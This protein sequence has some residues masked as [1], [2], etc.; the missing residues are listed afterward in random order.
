[1]R[2]RTHAAF[3][4]LVRAYSGD[5][6]RFAYWISRDTGIAEDIVQETFSR[7]WKAWHQLKD[8]NAAKAW[9]LTIAR[10]EFYRLCQR[11]RVAADEDI[12]EHLEL[13]ANYYDPADALAMRQALSSLPLSYREPLLMQVLGGMSCGEIAAAMNLSEGA[14]MTRLTRARQALR[15]LW[16]ADTSQIKTYELP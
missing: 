6:Y 8:E 10:N 15:K 5:V 11:R 16:E 3:E 7:A 12:D 14:V 2:L 13:A 4:T 1:M 9:L